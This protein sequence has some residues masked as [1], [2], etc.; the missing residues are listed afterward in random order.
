MDGADDK[1]ICHAVYRDPQAVAGVLH[2]LGPRGKG[3][4]RRQQFFNPLHAFALHAALHRFVDGV[5]GEAHGDRR[6]GRDG[7]V[8]DPTFTV[9][10]EGEEPVQP[11]IRMDDLGQAGDAFG[12]GL[13]VPVSFRTD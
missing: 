8:S 10:R 9:L 13:A 1:T 11:L 6:L 2:D 12:V 4:V 5:N 7:A 3:R